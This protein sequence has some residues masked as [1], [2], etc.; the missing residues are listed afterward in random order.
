MDITTEKLFTNLSNLNE[1]QIQT[2]IGLIEEYDY[3][4]KILYEIIGLLNENI[5]Y[6]D[7]VNDLKNRKSYWDLSNYKIYQDKRHLE[8][9]L[10]EKP[11]EITEGETSCPKCHQKKVLVVEMQTRSA[12]EG[13]TYYIKC[14][15]P[16]CRAISKSKQ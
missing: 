16:T 14:F 11:P 10:L 6:N 9:A 13:Y 1:I 5:N 4:K 12:D 2:L 15:N 8:D 3:P 7:I